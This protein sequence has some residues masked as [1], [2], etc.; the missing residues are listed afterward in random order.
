MTILNHTNDGLYPEL[1]A[2]FRLVSHL[3]TANRDECIDSCNPEVH[4]EAP[5]RLRGALTRWSALGLFQ[6]EDENVRIND[7]FKRK[8]GESLN[9]HSARLPIACRSL[10]FEESNCL[11][12]W[13]E[14]TG[15]AGDFV[16][17]AAW[18]L[19]QDIYGLPESF[20]N[21]I[22]NIQNEQTAPNT[23]IKIIQNGNRW[24]DL[25]FWMRYLGF[26]TGDSSSF[27]VDPTI[28]VKAELP[29]IF[30]T[31]SDLPA[32]EF[33]TTLASRLP[34]LDYGQYRQAV[35]KVLNPT[36]WRPPANGHLSMSLSLTLRRLALDNV[37]RLEG[38]A[39]AG[40]SYRL[41]GRGYR[42]WL[43][44]ES[45]RWMGGLA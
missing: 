33:I 21:A 14:T 7:R 27:Q 4:K 42:T 20:D 37:I 9:A 44:F 41:T 31:R 25:R 38:K 39:D 8:R 22:E 45:V 29:S 3:G 12:L 16:R 17:G 34:I 6:T 5:T 10:V 35:E 18:L 13:G 15:I 28:A 36:A 19:A 32:Q 24:N 2:I 23:N 26:A 40:T 11:P 43:G 30:G 1:I